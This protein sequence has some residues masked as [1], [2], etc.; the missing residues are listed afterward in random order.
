MKALWISTLMKK[1]RLKWQ[2]Y[3]RMYDVKGEFCDN[4]PS[5][6]YGKLSFHELLDFKKYKKYSR[7][8]LFGPFSFLHSTVNHTLKFKDESSKFNTDL[9][10]NKLYEAYYDYDEV[11]F[12]MIRKKIQYVP[13]VNLY[14]SIGFFYRV[15]CYIS[16]CKNWNEFISDSFLEF[17]NTW[18]HLYKDDFGA[19]YFTFFD[20]KITPIFYKNYII[21]RDKD[22]F[23]LQQEVYRLSWIKKEE[24][25]EFDN[26]SSYSNYCRFYL[27]PYYNYTINDSER[28]AAAL[29]QLPTLSPKILSI[30]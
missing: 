15:D 26:V 5:M 14:Y 21:N 24:T 8:S 6:P 9:I 27:D 7:T 22:S 3:F 16:L 23:D 20:A 12:N 29:D 19:S 25:F 17:Y 18:H 2:R 10:F 13:L 4:S 1:F 28:T 11:M 30:L